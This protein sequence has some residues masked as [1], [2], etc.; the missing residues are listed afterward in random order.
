M[1]SQ[2]VTRLPVF[3]SVDVMQIS[4]VMTLAAAGPVL[5]VVRT[6]ISICASLT[7]QTPRSNAAA[8]AVACPAVLRSV[9]HCRS[10]R[11]L[12]RSG[13]HRDDPCT[14]RPILPPLRRR[15]N[16]WQVEHTEEDGTRWGEPILAWA[17]DVSG[18]VS[19]LTTDSDGVVYNLHHSRREYRLYHLDSYELDAQ[20]QRRAADISE[21]TS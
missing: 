20:G 17:L 1:G 16:G 15:G 3:G 4:Q 7:P 18:W 10:Q 14:T 5:S 19:P 13:R 9:P 21:G 8:S 12:T 2:I 11:F 6:L